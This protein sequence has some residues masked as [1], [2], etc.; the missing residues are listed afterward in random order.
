MCDYSLTHLPNRLAVDGQE[1]V[2]QPVFDSFAG[3]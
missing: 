3:G 2:V 1:L